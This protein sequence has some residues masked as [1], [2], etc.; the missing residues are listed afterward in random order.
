M[1]VQVGL[2]AVS[3]KACWARRRVVARVLVRK[4]RRESWESWIRASR[5]VA[6]IDEVF[7]VGTTGGH[8]GVRV[9]AI[10]G[11]RREG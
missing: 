11:L 1:R 4:R 5:F 6:G 10:L 8:A 7:G 9:G 3:A 2:A